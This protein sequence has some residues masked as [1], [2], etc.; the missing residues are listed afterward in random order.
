M[1]AYLQAKFTKGAQ[2][3][4]HLE[5]LIWFSFSDPGEKKIKIKDALHNTNNTDWFL[6]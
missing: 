6:Y 3:T 2:L 4:F 1:H 5:N